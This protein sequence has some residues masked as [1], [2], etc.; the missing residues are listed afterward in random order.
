MPSWL[1]IMAVSAVSLY[2]HTVL[3]SGLHEHFAVLGLV[4]VHLALPDCVDSQ[5]LPSEALFTALKKQYSVSNNIAVVD[6]TA[7]A[8]K[9]QTE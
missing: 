8:G 7:D 2:N 6:N 1:Y 9:T 5:S 3:C 4:L